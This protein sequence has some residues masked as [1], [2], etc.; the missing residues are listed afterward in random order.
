LCSLDSEDAVVQTQVVITNTW[1]EWA[2]MD[3]PYLH[4]YDEWTESKVLVPM[5]G[6]VPYPG[7]VGASNGAPAVVVT[8]VSLLTLGDTSDASVVDKYKSVYA[9]MD[10]DGSEVEFGSGLINTGEAMC[11][12]PRLHT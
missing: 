12:S 6:L 2:Y 4:C 3:Q 9:H 5:G 7:D 11:S 10:I 8:P 1:A